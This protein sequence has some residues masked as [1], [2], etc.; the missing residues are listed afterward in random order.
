MKSLIINADDIGMHPAVDDAVA[1]LVEKGIIGAASVMALGRPNRDTLAGMARFGADLGLH[2]D[3]TSEMAHAAYRRETSLS[4]LMLS[5]WSGT[6]SPAFVRDA[7]DGQLQRFR[8]LTG[9]L[10]DFIDGHQHVHQFPVIRN[11]LAELLEQHGAKRIRVRNSAA[12]RWRGPKAA[13]IGMLGSG[14]LARRLE[15]IG[16]RSNADF[17]GVY[18]LTPDA[19]LA[20]YWRGWLSSAPVRGGLVMCHPALKDWGG[21][22]FRVKE[23][24][25]L[26]SQQFR[27]LCGEFDIQPIN[28]RGN[29]L[30]GT[31]SAA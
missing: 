30:R 4:S 7:L 8:E 14:A 6:L 21:E 2:V 25:F 15:Q 18:D 12:R 23:Y 29:A 19:D 13:V 26:A 28:W 24:Q 31:E 27:E 16:C 1:E 20:A 5:A 11:A 22:P 10:P 9:R 17:M 3:F